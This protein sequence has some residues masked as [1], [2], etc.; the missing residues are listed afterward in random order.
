MSLLGV[1]LTLL[2]GK[3]VPTTAPPQM[4]EAL[5]SVEV[6][7][8][9][10]APSGFQIAFR[11]ERSGMLD[12][13]DYPLL[14]SSLLSPFNRVILI[15]TFNGFPRV[16][17]D[18]VITHQQLSQSNDPGA[19]TLTVTGED[20]SVIMDLE[21]KSVEHPAL[22]ETVIATKII[23]SYK[24]YGLIP[25]VRPPLI[26]DPPLIVDRVPVQQE[27]DLEYLKTMAKRHAYV[28]YLTP[29]RFPFSSIAYW[30]PPKRLDF[31]QR[32]ITVNMGHESNVIGK[33]DFQNDSLAVTN[34]SGMVQDRITNQSQPVQNIFTTQFPLSSQPALL[35]QSYVRMKR[36]RAEGGLN[37]IQ[38]MGR[39]QAITDASINTIKA[40]GELDSLLYNG[41]LQ[42]RGLVG[43]RGAGYSYDGIYYVKSVTHVIKEGSYKQR[44]ILIRDGLGSTVPLVLP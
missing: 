28:F 32:A 26:L 20:L 17:M 16:L 6:T 38:A 43:L 31:P 37:I 35:M 27:T 7:H 12:I 19:S 22:D 3:N 8:S 34:V 5:E 4:M 13:F 30:G 44:F 1:Q 29:G 9:D 23:I 14:S 25:D 42:S 21:E 15:V 39:A 2:I 24:E 10:E 11:A 33:I 18:G 41:L 40:E 36:F